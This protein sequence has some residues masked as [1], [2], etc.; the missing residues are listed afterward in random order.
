MAEKTVVC[1]IGRCMLMTPVKHQADTITE[2]NMKICAACMFISFVR[3][4]SPE[5]A[6]KDSSHKRGGVFP[7]CP[8]G[9][10]AQQLTLA[11]SFS[12]G[13]TEN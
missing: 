6:M 8:R 10:I 7:S 5:Y 12:S 2:W 9:V 1:Y 11:T 3:I 4:A 13:S